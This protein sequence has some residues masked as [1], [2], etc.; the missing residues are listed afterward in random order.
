[1]HYSMAD[2]FINYYISC[3]DTCIY[4][5]KK[6]VPKY[7]K[8]TMNTFLSEIYLKKNKLAQYVFRFYQGFCK[9]Q[10]IS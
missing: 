5:K 6:I 1:M 9:N 7:D 3:R 2:N 10:N 4:T 8:Y